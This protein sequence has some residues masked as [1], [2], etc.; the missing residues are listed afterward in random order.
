MVWLFCLVFFILLFVSEP[1]GSFMCLL[2]GLL[3]FLA[4]LRLPCV[5]M[6]VVT[7]LTCGSRA[8]VVPGVL[9]RSVQEEQYE[10]P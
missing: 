10:K 1:V 5:L 2:A 7:V 4:L 9:H 8:M 3:A 6:F